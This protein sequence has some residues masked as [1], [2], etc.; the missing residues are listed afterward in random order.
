MT[1][2]AMLLLLSVILDFRQQEVIRCPDHES[3]AD[4]TQVVQSRDGT[5]RRVL[6]LPSPR[7]PGVLCLS[8]ERT[9]TEEWTDLPERGG[10]FLRQLEEPR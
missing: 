7:G 4:R 6:G 3:I 1:P 9:W 10:R 5:Y 8:P 2:G